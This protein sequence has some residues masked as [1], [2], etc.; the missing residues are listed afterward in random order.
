[1]ADVDLEAR[2]DEL[3]AAD[4]KDFTP[5]RDALVRDLK[6]ADRADEA[7]EVKALRKPTVAV[8]AVN[9][10]ARDRADQVA[11][12]V[13]LG[14]EL[15]ALQAEAKPDRDELRDLTRQRRTL[16]HQLTEHAAGTTERPDGARAAIAAT[17]DA[18][19]LDDELRDDLQ[20]GR[21]TQ[22]LSPAARFVLG[23]DDAPSPRAAPPRR[24]GRTARTAAPPRDELAAR[25]ARVELEAA[26]ERA[27]DAEEA[28]REHT[29]VAAEATE[30]L[31]AAHRQIA[32]LEAAL[33]DARAELADAKRAERDAQRA[34]KR[35]RTEQE[36]V[37]AALHAAERAADETK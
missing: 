1:M 13:D 21:L 16:L 12:L 8:A 31:D 17:L 2:L 14:R 28:V 24:S 23:D 35:A 29:E 33:A 5:T 34:E 37:T 3:F 4:A 11:D 20:R 10:A 25:R 7:A 30:R 22:E 6:A 26:R 18:A 19:S 15:A 36:R 27:E 32:D 9:R